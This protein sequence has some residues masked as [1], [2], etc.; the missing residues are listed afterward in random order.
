MPIGR[1][2]ALLRE[3][4]SLYRPLR[5]AV[6][7]NDCICDSLKCLLRTI[8]H[9]LTGIFK[10]ILGTLKSISSFISGLFN[11]NQYKPLKRE[12]TTPVHDEPIPYR[13]DIVKRSITYTGGLILGAILYLFVYYV[14]IKHHTAIII[15]VALLLMLAYLIVLENSH[16]IRSILMLCLP[17]MFT[18]RGRALIFCFMLAILVSGP[19]KNSQTNV[20]ELHS[21]LN[22]CK[23]YLILKTDKYVDKNIVQGLV[24]VEDVIYKLVE[25]IKEFA[26]EVKTKFRLILEYAITVEQYISAAID[27]LKELV[28]VCNLHTQ[29]LYINC[30]QT[31]GY[32]YQNCREQLGSK[33]DLLC[34]IVR[35]LSDSCAAVKIPDALCAIPIAI[36]QYIDKTIGDRLRAYIRIIENEFYVEVNVEHIYS[37]NGTKTKS[38]AKVFKEIIYDLEQKFWYVHLVSRLFNLVS[39]ILVIWILVTATLY[40]MHYLTELD[41]DNMYI[42]G[43]IESADERFQNK[44][45]PPDETNDTEPLISDDFSKPLS[46]SQDNTQ[47][48]VRPLLPML[49]LHAKKYLRP[50]S[51]SMNEGERHKLYIAGFVWLIITGYISFFV[52]LDY[53]FYQLIQFVTTTLDEIL[54]KSDLPLIDIS[55]KSG[56]HSVRY[57]RTYL[58]ELRNRKLKQPITINR[59]RNGS[60]SAMYRRLMD[61]IEKNIPDDVT[62]LDSMQRCLPRASKPDYSI[63]ETLLYLGIVTF[64]AVII[65][66]YALRTRHCIANLYYPMRARKRAFWLYDKLIR[67]RPMYENPELLEKRGHENRLIE[68]GIKAVIG[69][70]KD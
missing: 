1:K 32:A 54:F 11:K 47:D 66:A 31:F 57:N 38:D 61:S 28:N 19:I 6:L 37:Y 2:R 58:G 52:T 42:D 44:R 12:K 21:S 45:T 49:P 70:L 8:N 65:E 35:P 13:D 50:F 20:I 59:Y 68:L 51:I 14:L 39:L 69:R 48:G 9:G 18:N 29:D 30:Q 55:S 46:K 5:I 25:N 10:L 24:K 23:Q 67:E 34:E 26:R 36:V 62:I 17:I 15:M 27:K 63:Y 56:D 33:F 4:V 22:C 53:A 60:L 16:S 40:H 3:L 64:C 7:I 43:Y 41:F